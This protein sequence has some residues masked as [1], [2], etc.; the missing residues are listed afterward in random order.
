[1]QS[2]CTF[3]SFGLHVLNL[4]YCALQTHKRLIETSTVEETPK[5]RKFSEGEDEKDKQR[6]VNLGRLCDICIQVVSLQQQL[7]VHSVNKVF[8][9]C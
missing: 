5:K 8:S 6:F 7:R 9:N 3:G 1:M 2:L 4:I